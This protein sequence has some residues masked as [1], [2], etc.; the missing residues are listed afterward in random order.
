MTSGDVEP[1][2]DLS[3]VATLLDELK[4]ADVTLRVNAMQHLKQIT[5]ALGE[6]RT[7]EELIPFLTETIEDED[8]VLQVLAEQLGKLIDLVGGAKYA[9]SLLPP[10]E[11]LC[12]IE[13]KKVRDNAVESVSKIA[14][15]VSEL[16]NAEKIQTGLSKLLPMVFRLANGEWFTSRVAACK[17]LPP[18]CSCLPKDEASIVSKAIT[19]F[20]RLARD[21][22]PAVRREAAACT[23]DLAEA[24]VLVD[25]TFI[26]NEI[27][28]MLR[29]LID[30]EQDSVRVLAIKSASLVMSLLPDHL[31]DSMCIPVIRSVAQDKAWRVRY[32]FADQIVEIC[33]SVSAKVIRDE[34]LPAFLALLKDVEAEVRTVIASRTTETT[35]RIIH[36]ANDDPVLNGVDIAVRDI[37]P[38]VQE[39][40]NDPSQHVRA[41]IALNVMGLAPELGEDVT[42]RDLLDLVLILLKDEFPTVRLNVIST[43]DS[44]SFVMGMRTLSDELLPAIVDLA[45]DRNWRVRLAIIEHIPLLAQ[46]LGQDL[47]DEEMRL[48]DVCL[49]WLGDCVWSIREAAINNLKNLTEVFGEDWAQ[50]NIVPQIVDLFTK[51][52]N[53]LYRM[54]ALY[55]IGVLCG[56]VGPETVEEEFLP[57]VSKFAC[58]DPVPNVRFSAAKTMDLLIPKVTPELQKSVIRPCL[59]EVLN[60][61]EEDM[62]VLYFAKV[63]L[64]KIE[65]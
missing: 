13:E 24:S 40:V 42:V 39:L 52:S 38:I 45:E 28:P 17:L 3:S 54:T 5:A 41:A 1:D 37:L 22:T 12:S 49:T 25:P 56:V 23:G 20:K 21:P 47:F 53:Y 35:K 44:V 50:M 16:E 31:Q 60:T 58:K 36:S 34:I 62:D 10:L 32:M 14:D 59:E 11:I 2:G 15:A 33:D 29:E 48:S 7:R 4:D 61:P 55:A 64:E 8:E 51:S 63:A 6:E 65:V 57:L 43:L 9:Q 18:S 27:F 46:H 26:E 30:D 19:L